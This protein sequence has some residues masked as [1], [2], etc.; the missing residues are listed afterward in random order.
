[1]PQ[2][3]IRYGT[4]KDAALIA[5]LI[6][7]MVSEMA[8]FGGHAVDYSPEVWSSMA[9]RVSANSA[10]HEHIYLIASEASPAQTAV[11]LIAANIEP[12]GDVFLAKT[13]LHISAIYTVPSAR[14]QGVAR[15][16]IQEVVKWGQQLNTVEVDLHVLIANPARRLY[17]Q[18]GFQPHE[19]SMV[20]KLNND[21][22]AG[23]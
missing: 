10:R 9:E 19:I 21:Q 20:K 14:R 2:I 5:E 18:L 4:T 3:N 13:R 7:N 23:E 12:L 15:Q 1:M 8:Q 17:E 11:G 22:I 16:L 6:E